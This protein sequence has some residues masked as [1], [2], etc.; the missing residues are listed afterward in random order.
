M[1]GSKAA[2]K[3]GEG[4]LDKAWLWGLTRAIKMLMGEST[5]QLEM[6]KVMAEYSRLEEIFRCE[7]SEDIERWQRYKLTGYAVPHE[8][9]DAW[10]GSWG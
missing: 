10:L 8:A 2:P 7:K 5:Q 9:V 1:Q 6:M 3:Q 4:Y